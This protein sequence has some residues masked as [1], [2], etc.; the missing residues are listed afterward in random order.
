M[1]IKKRKKDTFMVSREMLG[2]Y[3]SPC[4]R[5]A[6]VAFASRTQVQGKHIENHGTDKWSCLSMFA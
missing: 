2:T 4:N 1:T 6:A 3:G 5:N